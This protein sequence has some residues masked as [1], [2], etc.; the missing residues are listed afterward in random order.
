MSVIG[1]SMINHFSLEGITDDSEPIA[2][3]NIA[4]G[5]VPGKDITYYTFWEPMKM[6]LRDLMTLIRKD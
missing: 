5:T 1:M 4:S 2:L 6:D 3:C